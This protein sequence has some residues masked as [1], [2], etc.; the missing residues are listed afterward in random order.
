MVKE[1]DLLNFLTEGDYM[2][3]ILLFLVWLNV[4]SNK[5]FLAKI[6]LFFGK[7][8][9]S[10]EF[11][12]NNNNRNSL[13]KNEVLLLKALILNLNGKFLSSNEALR[14]ITFGSRKEETQISLHLRNLF[15]MSRYQNIDNQKTIYYTLF[16]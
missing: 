14:K 8:K 6:L 10:L 12:E 4:L 9:Q 5:I 1:L 3:Y 11:L 2:K 15:I 16:F 7:Y 13:I